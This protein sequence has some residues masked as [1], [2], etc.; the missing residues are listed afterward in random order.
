MRSIGRFVSHPRRTRVLHRRR[1]DGGGKQKAQHYSSLRIGSPSLRCAATTVFLKGRRWS[2]G[3]HRPD[4]RDRSGDSRRPRQKSTSPTQLSR[5]VGCTVDPP[6]VDD[7]RTGLDPVALDHLRAADRGDDDVG[8]AD[9]AGRSLVREWA[10]VTVRSRRSAAGPSASRR[11]S[12]GRSQRLPSAGSPEYFL[13]SLRQPSGVHGTSASSPIASRPALTGWK[14][15]TSLAG[16]TPREHRLRVD[17][18]GS[19]Q[20]NQ[21]PVDVGSAL[22]WS[23]R[24]RRSAWVVSAGACARSFPCPL[25][26]RLAPSSGHRRRSADARRPAL[27]RDPGAPDMRLKAAATSRD[28]LRATRRRRPFRR[29]GLRSCDRVE[30]ACSAATPLSSG[31]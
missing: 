18:L 16:S 9:D 11:C 7:G 12:T 31:R 19:G 6:D 26:G 27:R 15:S 2:S 4:R 23:T 30:L 8:A 3:P 17:L 25:R 20:L 1:D 24:S 22:S 29:S 10:T 28:L 14:P 21:D 13:S 5:S